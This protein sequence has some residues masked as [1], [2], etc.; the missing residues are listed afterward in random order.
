MARHY[1]AAFLVLSLA[2]FTV[3]GF[4]QSPPTATDAFNLRI[5]C[6]RMSEEKAQYFLEGDKKLEWQMV[7]AWNTS[8]YDPKSNR[9]YGRIYEHI[10]KQR[11]GFDNESDQLF[12][13][14][15]DNESDQFIGLTYDLLLARAEIVNGRKRAHIYDPDSKKHWLPDNCDRGCPA[16]FGDQAWQAAEDYMNEFMADPRKR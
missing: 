15:L 13:L 9:C 16:D 14:H 6:K 3:H 12:D 1:R 4:A 7:A 2:L 11:F 8:K 10:T 5:Q